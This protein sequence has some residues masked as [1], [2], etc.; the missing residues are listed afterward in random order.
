MGG[1]KK[2]GANMSDHSEESVMFAKLV[3]SS[4]AVLRCI[5][6]S[7][8]TL[9]RLQR[10]S[11]G[12]AKGWFGAVEA[13][14]PGTQPR[15]AAAHPRR[16]RIYGPSFGRTIRFRGSLPFAPPAPFGPLPSRP[17]L[18]RIVR[19][20]SNRRLSGVSRVRPK[21]EAG[22]IGFFLRLVTCAPFLR[23]AD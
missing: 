11:R 1:P 4:S 5:G 17:Y 23:P 7:Y 13:T 6:S 9:R 18:R 21:A 16:G 3:A 8:A 15:A 20:S 22:I 2:G 10:S 12:S 14:R 19:D